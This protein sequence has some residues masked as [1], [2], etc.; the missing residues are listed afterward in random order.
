MYERVFRPDWLVGD[1][2]TQAD[3]TVGCMFT[4]M[5]EALELERQP[6]DYPSL[7]ALTQRCEASP[8][9]ATQA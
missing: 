2:M 4:F 5:N 7:R 8:P 9:V 6:A 1:R 3:I